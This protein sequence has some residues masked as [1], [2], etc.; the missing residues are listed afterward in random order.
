MYN[1][2]SKVAKN[3]N[4]PTAIYKL[5]CAHNKKYVGKTQNVERRMQQHFSGKGSQV[6]QKFK[7]RDGKILDVVPGYLSSKAEQHHTQQLIQKHGYNN[8]RGGKYVNSTT[9]Q[10]SKNKVVCYKCKQFGHYANQCYV[11]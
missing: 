9:L 7:P 6:T 11:C 2:K 4:A 1:A 8:V 5:N 3:I 10:K